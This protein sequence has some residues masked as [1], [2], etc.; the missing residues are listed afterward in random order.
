MAVIF[1]VVAIPGM[2]GYE[3]DSKLYK[4]RT[5]PFSFISK[6]ITNHKEYHFPR[7]KYKSLLLVWLVCYNNNVASKYIKDHSG[8]KDPNKD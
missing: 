5:M 3:I 1:K 2:D 6:Q 7:Q 4:M 8:S